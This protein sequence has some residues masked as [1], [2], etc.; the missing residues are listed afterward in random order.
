MGVADLLYFVQCGCLHL[1]P[2]LTSVKREQIE[3]DV[4]QLRRATVGS[5]RRE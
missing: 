1:I 2:E 3:E 5:L 4:L